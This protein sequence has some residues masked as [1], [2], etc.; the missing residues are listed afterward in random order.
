[1]HDTAQRMILLVEDDAIIALAK[2]SV[3]EGFGYQVISAYSGRE[4]VEQ[5]L[6]NS[7]IS[8]VL[9]DIDLGAGIDGPE[10]A[11]RILAH[12]NIPIVF[13]TSHSEAEFVN[14]VRAITRYGYVLKNSG[15]FVLK[16]S[17]E[18]AFEL[19]R[20]H[21]EL[22]ARERYY[23]EMFQQ[24]PLGY[25]SLNG[26]GRFIEVNQTWLNTLGY[27]REEVLGRWFG[28]F[29]APDYREQFRVRFP[30]FKAGGN[31]HSEFQM[32]HRDGS[33]RLIA[34]EGRIGYNP[35]GTFKQTHCLLSDITATGSAAQ[36]SARTSRFLDN[37]T[38]LAYE[39]DAEGNVTYVNRAAERFTGLPVDSIAGRPFLQF[40]MEKDHN[41]LIDV[42]RRTLQGEELE[43]TL[44]FT[45]GIV[46]HF[47]SL[48]MYDQNQRIIGTFGIARDITLQQETEERLHL[49]SERYRKA[50]AL[51]KVGNWEYNIKTG[52]FWGSDEA[53]RIYGFDPESEHFST[54]QVEGCIPDRESVHKALSDLIEEGREYNLEFDIITNDTGDRRIIASRADLDRDPDGNPWK[55]NGVIQDITE[56][57][58][59]E[60]KLKVALEQKGLLLKELNHRVKNNLSLISSLI[61][62][63]ESSPESRQELADVAHQIDAIQMIHAAIH[64]TD[65]ITDIDAGKYFNNLL[66]SIFS[67]FCKQDVVVQCSMPDIRMEI[68]TAIPLGLIL[69]E[70]AINA[71]KYGYTNGSKYYFKVVMTEDREMNCYRLIV[72]NNGNEFP[73]T[74]DLNNPETLG[75][76]LITSLTEQIN[77]SVSLEKRPNT[78]FTITFPT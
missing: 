26:E 5:A 50:Q 19:F 37:I 66:T 16:T 44:T 51:G 54:D 48:P 67:T 47:T 2:S 10:A 40:F 39:A 9:M 27:R 45:T 22:S 52:E 77:G 34:F 65:D 21:A 8:L 61:R 13:L 20:A 35:D 70:M 64:T 53:K 4:A 41:S 28:D 42:Y 56:R 31:I 49:N 74:V 15:D 18:M 72:S 58:L 55:V 62:L 68:D 69:N 29:L 7:E 1:M 24:A 32:I 23:L 3:I 36:K 12:R 43:N 78:R 14:R 33:Q 46:C 71:I 30:I 73:V 25:Q 60:E 6:G 75:L 63:K 59:I 17:I 11:R 57:K 38:D 76:R